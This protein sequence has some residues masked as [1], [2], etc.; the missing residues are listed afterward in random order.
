[1]AKKH[2]GSCDFPEAQRPSGGGSVTVYCK[3]GCGNKSSAYFE[4]NNRERHAAGVEEEEDRKARQK[5]LEEEAE[6]WA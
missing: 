1:M 3:L 4:P 6:G 5:R 2:D